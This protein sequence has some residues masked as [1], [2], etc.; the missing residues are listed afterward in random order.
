MSCDD[1]LAKLLETITARKAADPA[2]SYTAKLF[3]AGRSKIAQKLGEEAVEAAIAATRGRRDE[4]INESADLLFHLLVMLA[5][6]NIALEE[7]M[8][9]LKRR[10]GISGLDEKA[11]RPH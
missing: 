4:V 7:V 9:E 3:A 2:S 11:N 5:E 1:T 6:Q 10:E 8:N